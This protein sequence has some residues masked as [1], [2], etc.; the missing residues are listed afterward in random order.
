M[1]SSVWVQVM[2]GLDSADGGVTLVDAQLEE[3]GA[4]L[5]RG[6]SLPNATI[7]LTQASALEVQSVLGGNL[8]ALGLPETGQ[9][10][11]SKVRCA[12]GFTLSTWQVASGIRSCL[13]QL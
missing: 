10:V 12:A 7:I 6:F 11:G 8:S 9:A 4:N 3:L 5:L 13:H 1:N 2:V